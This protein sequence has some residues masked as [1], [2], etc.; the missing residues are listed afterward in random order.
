MRGFCQEQSR[1]FLP[2]HTI[3]PDLDLPETT[4]CPVALVVRYKAL[5]GQ[6]FCAY[7]AQKRLH[8]CYDPTVPPTYL[9]ALDREIGLID[10]AQLQRQQKAAKAKQQ[11]SKHGGR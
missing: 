8:L 2:A 10:A 3:S 11:R 9:V 1:P 7:Q 5:V 6:I 4:C